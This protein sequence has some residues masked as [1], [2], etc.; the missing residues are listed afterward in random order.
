MRKLFWS[1]DFALPPEPSESIIF[2]LA[3][4]NCIVLVTGYNYCTILVKFL[5]LFYEQHYTI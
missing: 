4:G 1:L 3:L 5:D 2:K